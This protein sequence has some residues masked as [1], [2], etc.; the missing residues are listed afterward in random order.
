MAIGLY[1]WQGPERGSRSNY[2]DAIS[3]LL[4]QFATGTAVRY[5]PPR[6]ADLV[7]S[8]SLLGH[9]FADQWKRRLS[10]PFQPLV[11]WGTGSIQESDVLTRSGL[12]VLAVRGELTR[13]ALN[14][15][16]GL[17]LGD[18]GLL[19]PR[20]LG[21]SVRRRIRWGIV[22]HYVDQ[23]SSSVRALAAQNPDAHVID[24]TNPDVLDT[25]R[26]IA[27]CD[28]ILSSSLHGLIVADA[29]GIPNVHASWGDRV[30]GG[31]W[32]FRDYASSV[33]RS[34]VTVDHVTALRDLES[35]ATHADPLI[36]ARRC[37]ELLAA[38]S[39]HRF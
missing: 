6:L 29:F 34:L 13:A 30:H 8:G 4:V 38:I 25:T 35:L 12:K 24:V 32:K 11:V 19:L 39:R 22:P 14:L 15:P 16:E 17:P 31:D 5:A 10:R 37:D 20:L 26:Q 7:A 21:E 23:E 2:G 36:V 28:F 1:W 27:E 3:P 18:P 9:V 33:G